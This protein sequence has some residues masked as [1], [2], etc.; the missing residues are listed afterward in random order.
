VPRR[1]APV[2]GQ[3]GRRQPAPVFLRNERRFIDSSDGWMTASSLNPASVCSVALTLNVAPEASRVWRNSSAFV[4]RHPPTPGRR[5][6]LPRQLAYRVGHRHAQPAWRSMVC[7][8][9]MR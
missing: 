2:C 6:L 8:K 4:E 7:V 3:P 1:R 5:S 9:R